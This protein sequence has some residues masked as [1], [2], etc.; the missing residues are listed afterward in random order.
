MK[1]TV[2]DSQ[3]LT[4]LFANTIFPQQNENNPFLEMEIHCPEANRYTNMFLNSNINA[5]INFTSPSVDSV[6][7]AGLFSMCKELSHQPFMDTSKCINMAAMFKGCE[8][9]RFSVHFLDTKNVRDMRQM[10]WGCK[11]FSGNGIQAFDFSSLSNPN[12]MRNFM[13]GGAYVRQVHYDQFIEN[14]YNQMKAGTLPTPMAAVEM[15]DSKY[16]PYYASMRQEVI[17]YGWELLDG[18]QAV[19]TVEPSKWEKEF[20]NGLYNRIKDHPNNWLDE[21]DMSCH[22]R[23]SQG[24]ILISPRHM[25][26]AYHYRPVV[27][28]KVVFWNGQEGTVE[29]VDAFPAT[30]WGDIV[31]V[32]LKEAVQ[33]ANPVLFLQKNW[34]EQCPLM[35]VYGPPSPFFPMENIPT[36]WIDKADKACVSVVSFISEWPT[37]PNLCVLIIPQ[38]PVFRSKYKNAIPG[39]S[40][41]PQCFLYNKKFV[42]SHV[43]TTGGPGGG[44]WLYADGCIDY[45]E[46]EISLYG[47]KLNFLGEIQ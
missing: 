5:R 36:I 22:T 7:Y 47:E 30:K 17:D 4:L 37:K 43:I 31:L 11:N 42:L 45:I 29:N 12:A 21:V 34:R 1:I 28:K 44:S 40:G 27:G 14:L 41:S 23:S 39:D 33:N 19:R 6:T 8:S 13:G 38:N 26:Y 2:S 20:Y 3:D 9:M 16:S 35:G 18:G 32:R 10:F 46:K 24:G 15:G 25:I